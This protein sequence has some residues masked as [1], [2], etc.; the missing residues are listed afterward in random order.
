MPNSRKE[1]G[2]ALKQHRNSLTETLKPHPA[3]VPHTEAFSFK[4]TKRARDEFLKALKLE[5]PELR[6]KE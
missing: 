3:R 5:W 4:A 6:Q 1:L 2:K